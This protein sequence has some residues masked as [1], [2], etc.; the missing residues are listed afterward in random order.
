MFTMAVV[1]TLGARSIIGVTVIIEKTGMNFI[2]SPNTISFRIYGEAASFIHFTIMCC[3]AAPIWLSHTWHK[4]CKAAHPKNLEQKFRG[5]LQ[6]YHPRW[7]PQPKPWVGQTDLSHGQGVSRPTIPRDM[8]WPDRVDFGHP[9]PDQTD[10]GHHWQILTDSAQT[11]GQIKH[12]IGQT[13]KR[14][15]E[16]HP[17]HFPE[18]ETKVRFEKNV[19]RKK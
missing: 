14:A 10:L 6:F 12:T 16:S 15:E 3:F 18:G 4:Y 9:W 7:S 5:L 13:Q 19:Y 11:I 1:N 2:A 17:F 8:Y